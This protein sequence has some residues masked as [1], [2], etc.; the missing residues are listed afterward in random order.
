MV[1]FPDQGFLFRERAPELLFL[2]FMGRHVA[3]D[4]RE[5][6]Q[7]ALVVTYL[8]QYSTGEELR[9]VFA[10]VPSLVLG[11]A[12][13]SRRFDFVVRR[14]FRYVLG[15]EDESRTSPYGFFFFP[16]KQALRAGVPAQDFSFWIHLK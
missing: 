15:S 14:S 6:Y 5:A 7:L 16:A 9:A 12:V 2:L 10:N 8:G 13:C 11:A 4:F 3:H 1:N